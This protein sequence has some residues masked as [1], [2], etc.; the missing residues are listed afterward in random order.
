MPTLR[1]DM[2][3]GLRGD[4]VRSDDLDEYFLEFVFGV[5]IAELCESA[6]GE[7]LAGLDDADGVA[8]F[9]HFGHDVGGKDDGLAV[10]AAL[11]DEG[12]DGAGLHNVEAVTRVMSDHTRAFAA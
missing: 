2:S 4:V 3:V 10:V 12:G 7:E 5:F 11:A 8:E 9:F 6:F 1:S